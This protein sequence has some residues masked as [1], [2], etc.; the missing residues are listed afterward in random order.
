MDAATAIHKMQTAGFRLAIV[1]ARL[2]VDPGDRLT[3]AQCAFIRDHKPEIVAALRA[4]TLDAS[5]TSDHTAANDDHGNTLAPELV[6]A[7]L[8]VCEG[9]GD[10]QAAQRAMI[11]DLRHY[12][13]ADY[14]KLTAYFRERL[15]VLS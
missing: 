4:E 5:S 10:D 13:A 14:P 1:D 3:E 7:A 11:E 6:Q 2:L 8:R 9:Y 15:E 12:P